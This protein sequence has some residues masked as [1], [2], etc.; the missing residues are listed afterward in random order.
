MHNLIEQNTEAW[1]LM[2][3]GKLTGSVASKVMA[4]DGKAFG[5]PAKKL[6]VNIA[7][8]QI[9]GKPISDGYTNDHMERGHEQE[10]IARQLYEREYFCKVADGGFYDNGFT[11][12]S[13]DGLVSTDGII[14]I[15]CVIP[16]VQYKRIK[17]KS[18]DSAYRWQLSFNLKES[19]RKWIDYISF[20][21][22]FPTDRMLFVQ[23]IYTTDLVDDFKSIDLRVDDFFE[24]V[25]QIKEDIE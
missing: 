12:C 8:E 15:K 4:N 22:E 9:T 13:P 2:R 23:R 19:G 24:L 25:N 3:S 21:A 11:G 16:S 6:A 1:F 17:T 5:D 10:P 7:L 20:C 18:F 14:E